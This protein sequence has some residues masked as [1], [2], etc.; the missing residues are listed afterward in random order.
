M[1]RATQLTSALFIGLAATAAQAEILDLRQWLDTNGFA[2]N[3]ATNTWQGRRVDAAGALMAGGSAW[4]S[5]GFPVN[6]PLFGPLTSPGSD[7]G[8]AGPATF[9][10]VWMHP[11]SGTP[12]AAVFA[13]QSPVWAGGVSVHWEFIANGL[14]GNGIRLSVQATIGGVTSNLGSPIVLTGSDDRT[15]FFAL[16]SVIQMQP[17]DSIAVIFDDN[18]SYLFDHLNFNATIGIPAP[19]AAAGLLVVGLAATRRR[20]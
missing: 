15:D 20:R 12:A 5:P 10:G 19:G 18:G 14:S 13:P 7:P 11:G 2:S 4:I 3:V 6:T 17:G 8:A 1:S 9:N 16:P